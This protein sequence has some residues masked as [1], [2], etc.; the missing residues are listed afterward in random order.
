M[1]RW[2]AGCEASPSTQHRWTHT[3]HRPA[4]AGWSAPAARPLGLP[5]RSRPTLPPTGSTSD[6]LRYDKDN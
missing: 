6:R 5:P 2:G 4:S 3:I 1:T